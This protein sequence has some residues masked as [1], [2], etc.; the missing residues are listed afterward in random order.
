MLA[1]LKI[2]FEVFD[3]LSTVTVDGDLA[4]LSS[5]RGKCLSTETN[6]EESQYSR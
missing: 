4:D 1:G 3:Y 2:T 5:I 6:K